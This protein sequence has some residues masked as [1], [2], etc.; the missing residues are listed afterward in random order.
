MR[1]RAALLLAAVLAAA[2]SEP[3]RL[4]PRLE[5]DRLKVRIE[6]ASPSSV[7]RV[8]FRRELPTPTEFEDEDFADLLAELDSG[9]RAEVEVP[10]Q[11]PM[12]LGRF[13]VRVSPQGT[14]VPGAESVLDERVASTAYLQAVLEEQAYLKGA[15]AEVQAFLDRMAETEALASRDRAA[16]VQA[17][18]EGREKGLKGLKAI[19]LRSWDSSRLFFPQT[20]VELCSRFVATSL[21]QDEMLRFAALR[22][23]TKYD[24]VTQVRPTPMATRDG[25]G[26]CRARFLQEC[27]WTRLAVMKAL[28]GRL[29][30]RDGRRGLDEVLAL[31]GRD[32]EDSPWRKDLEDLGKAFAAW[33]DADTPEL[34]ADLGRR[35]SALQEATGWNAFEAKRPALM[36]PLPLE[37]GPRGRRRTAPKP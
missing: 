20:H 10:L 1:R 34:K 14:S 5:G 26:A 17:W 27:A 35:F 13:R 3:L 37:S 33:A 32:L 11:G 36:T 31:W 23:G 7:L 4:E 12:G 28:V 15:F 16:A 22:A 9:G 30:R 25:L 21:I 6:G 19:L 29:G 18:Q 8:W 24:R 2:A